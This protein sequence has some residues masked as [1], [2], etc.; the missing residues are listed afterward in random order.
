MGMYVKF[1]LVPMSEIHISR[2][3]LLT[4]DRSGFLFPPEMRWEIDCNIFS[5]IHISLYFLLEIL[6]PSTINSNH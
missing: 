2:E 4:L 5:S 1:D 6:F 3:A